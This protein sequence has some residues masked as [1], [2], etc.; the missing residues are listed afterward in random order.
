MLGS[1]Y[2]S[3]R[4]LRRLL[5]KAKASVSLY[6]R[7]VEPVMGHPRQAET[8]AVARVAPGVDCSRECVYVADLRRRLEGA[9]TCIVG[10]KALALNGLEGLLKRC[11]ELAAPEGG[12]I[13]LLGLGLKPLYVTSDLDSSLL[14]VASLNHYTSYLLIHVHGDNHYRFSGI[15]SGYSIPVIYTSQVESPG[16]ALA[17]GGYTDGDRAA[18]F[19]MAMGSM[20][21]RMVGFGPLTKRDLEEMK[22]GA[23]PFKDYIDERILEASRMKY[24]LGMKLLAELAR[25][26]G[27]RMIRIGAKVLAFRRE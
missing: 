16:C 20:E 27:Y 15:A 25:I 13:A 10:P 6:Y 8:L 7:L 14:S 3:C 5:E 22:R 18:V 17:I 23:L 24:E 12:H 2:P 11:D 1:H 4:E 21:V 9:T 19:S 26:H